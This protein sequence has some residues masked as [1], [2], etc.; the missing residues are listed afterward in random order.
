MEKLKM[1]RKVSGRKGG[2]VSSVAKVAAARENG[3]RGGR[4][5]DPRIKAIMADRGCTRQ[6]AHQILKLLST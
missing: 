4:P 6:R 5:A 2:T 3:K 1:D